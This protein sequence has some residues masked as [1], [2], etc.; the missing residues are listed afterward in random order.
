VWT[1]GTAALALS[2]KM[3]DAAVAVSSPFAIT[4]YHV[5]SALGGDAAVMHLKRKANACGLRVFLDFVP[6]HVARDHPYVR[7]PPVPYYQC[8]AMDVE[9]APVLWQQPCTRTFIPVK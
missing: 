8:R 2:R 9:G 5:Q 6:N 4:D 7:R 3:V 1:T